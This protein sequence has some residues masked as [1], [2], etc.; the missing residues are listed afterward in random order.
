MQSK[1]RVHSLEVRQ[2]LNVSD[3]D[4]RSPVEG[5]DPRGRGSGPKTRKRSRGRSR[6]GL[7]S[8]NWVLGFYS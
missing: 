5:Y 3:R 8:Q 7:K 2:S 4:D 6:E 1:Q